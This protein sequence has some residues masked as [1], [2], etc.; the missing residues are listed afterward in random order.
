MSGN[1]P[2]PDPLPLAAPH[3]LLTGLLLLTFLLHIIPMNLV[4]G[5]SVL[6][7]QQRWQARRG[8]ESA[9]EISRWL[10]RMLPTAVAATVSFGVAPLLFVQVLYGRL[11]YTSSILIGWP[12]LMVIPILILAYYGTYLVAFRSEERSRGSLLLIGGVSAFL[13][14][15]IAFIYSNNM[16][17]ML[18]PEIFYGK[19]SNDPSGLNLN[20]GDPTL[21]P[22]YL[23]ML[24]GALAVTGLAVAFRGLHLEKKG[25]SAE[26]IVQRGNLLFLGSTGLNFILGTVFLLSFPREMLLQMVRASSPG[27]L[28]LLAG[29]FLGLVAMGFS[30]L[31]LQK[32]NRSLGLY[33][34]AGALLL[35]LVS[36]VILRDRVR[37]LM[38][39]DQMAAV[40]W[41]QPQ[42]STILLFALLLIA[43]LGLVGWMV[44]QLA[45]GSTRS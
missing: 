1:V 38:V 36:M 8:D 26:G 32:K 40:E 35:T 34:A 4:L 6:V 3:W 17:L 19:Y 14:L 21:F 23:H 20:L 28:A 10:V 11:L 15:V 43:A 41:I 16:S 31:A 42:W 29:F 24:V 30:V 22:R 44:I 7:F 37:A 45:R 13:F 5:G 9:R 33:G 18:R 12:W 2:Y 25:Q 27:T 39:S